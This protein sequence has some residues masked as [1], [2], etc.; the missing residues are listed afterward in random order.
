MGK[1]RYNKVR[2]YMS[3]KDKYIET[4]FVTKALYKFLKPEEVVIVTTKDGIGNAELLKKELDVD[5]EIVEISIPQKNEDTWEILDKINDRLTNGDEIVLDIT[6]AFRHIPFLSFVIVTY[7]EITKN[8]KIRGIYYGAYEARDSKNYVPIFDLSDALIFLNWI[9]AAKNLKDYGRNE[10]ISEILKKIQ[11]EIYRGKIDSQMKYTKKYASILENISQSIY[12]NQIPSAIKYSQQL[13]HLSSKVKKELDSYFKPLTLL[14]KDFT[15]FE[16]FGCENCLKMLT[17]ET[18]QRQLLIAKYQRDI[19][20]WGEALENLREWFVNFA[21]YLSNISNSLWLERESRVRVEWGITA[22]SKE[23][24]GESEE[25]ERNAEYYS[26]KTIIEKIERKTRIDPI[27]LWEKITSK[28]NLIAHGGMSKDELNL[29]AL[30]NSL[31]EILNN[32]DRLLA[33]LEEYK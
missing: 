21:F 13:S 11:D 17:K 24:R 12:L 8:I 16:K 26:L 25:I 4:C 23:R 31:N 15:I 20:L 3:S 7:L 19:G 14:Y 18:L 29:R 10:N 30:Q 28:R 1:G 32:C 27:S 5:T 22:L 2:Y 6:Y 33:Y 9:Y